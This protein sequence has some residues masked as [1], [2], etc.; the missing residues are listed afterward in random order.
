M[1]T[2][3]QNMRGFLWGQPEADGLRDP[4][5]IHISQVGD[6]VYNATAPGATANCG[7]TAVL[8]AIRLVGRDVPGS[9]RYRG[10]ALVEYVRYLGTGNTNKLVGTTNLHLQRVLELSG[11]HWRVLEHPTDILRAVRGGEPVIM[12][13]NPTAPGCYTARY[14]YIDIRRWDSGHWIVVSRFNPE[15]GTY[16]VND[17]QSTIGPIEA[18]DAELRAFSAKDGDF[19]IVVGRA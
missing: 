15:R 10:E 3:M 9:E 14:D 8:M 1:A 7:P 4:A 5:A 17:P 18:T 12:A 2:F 19:G 16:T 11:C 13:G 6:E